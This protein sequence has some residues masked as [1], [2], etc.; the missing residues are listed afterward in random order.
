MNWLKRWLPVFA[1]LGLVHAAAWMLGCPWYGYLVLFPVT[2]VIALIIAKPFQG[3]EPALNQATTFITCPGCGTKNPRHQ[4]PIYECYDCGKE[5]SELS[6][7][8]P[9]L[10]SK[11]SGSQQ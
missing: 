7:R 4:K 9:T 5:F 3:K 8:Y 1:I 10:P 2:L 6:G 11:V